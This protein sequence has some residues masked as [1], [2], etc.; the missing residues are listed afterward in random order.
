MTWFELWQ[1][2]TQLDLQPWITHL[3]IHIEPIGLDSLTQVDSA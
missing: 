3:N 1:G 2:K